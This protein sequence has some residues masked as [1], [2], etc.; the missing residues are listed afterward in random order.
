MSWLLNLSRMVDMIQ[1]CTPWRLFIPA[2]ICAFLAQPANATEPAGQWQEKTEI[3]WDA[4]AAKLVRR[5]FRVFDPHPELGLEFHWLPETESSKQTGAISG[6]GELIWYRKGASPYDRAS[7]FSTY[8]GSLKDGLPDGW[9]TLS[10]RSGLTY[11]GAWKSGRMHGFGSIEFETGERYQGNFVEG[12]PDG[13]GKYIGANGQIIDGSARKS[14]ADG[15][16]AAAGPGWPT[17]SLLGPSLPLGRVRSGQP[18]EVAQVSGPITMSLYIDRAKNNEF[19]EGGGELESFVY[20]QTD[21]SGTVEIRLDAPKIMARWK[22]DGTITADGEAFTLDPNQFGP[23]FLV[24]DLINDGDRAAQIVGGYIDVAESATDREPY[25]E[26]SSIDYFMAEAKLDPTF[27]FLNEGWGPVQNA[28]ITYYFGKEPGG[29]T[30]VID[31]GTFDQSKEV[32]TLPGFL[33]S[34]LNVSGVTDGHFPCPSEDEIPNC[35]ANLVQ[36]GLFG[37]LGGAMFAE[38]THVYTQVSGVIDYSWTD[39]RGSPQQRQSPISVKLPVLDF[40]IGPV[41]EYGAPEAVNRKLP[42]IKLALDRKDYR[43][44]FSY[45]ERLGAQQNKRFALTLDAEKSSHHLFRIVLQ[46][47]DGSTVS[48]PPVDLLMF[49]PRAVQLY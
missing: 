18:K 8:K 26:I 44:P 33:A 11:E 31:A 29:Q 6:A 17:L 20:D 21:A 47:A 5:S 15:A 7:R 37:Q 41:A 24:V 49:K 28:K 1:V 48:T 39:D 25:L 42:V 43:I 14:K 23:V 40:V 27:A 9:G 46:L 38:Y 45:R 36:S 3:V 10:M 13:S 34:G 19:K 30:F 16:V 35:L 12:E 4:G 32:S 2:T 22:G